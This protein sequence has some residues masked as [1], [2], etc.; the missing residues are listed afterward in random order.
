MTTKLKLLTRDDILAIDDTQ[1]EVVAVPEWG[2]SVTVR[3]LTGTERDQ[4]EASFVTYQ[5]NDKGSFDVMPPRTANVRARLVAI[6]TVGEDGKPLFS[7]ADVAAL[8]RKS[9]LALERVADVARKLAGMTPRD[10]E[11]LEKGL[12][13][14]QNGS[15]GSD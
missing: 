5:R 8:G 11:V 6:A 15:S 2:G 7:E 13:A 10:L 4:F 9:G 1:S 3:G 14:D 12:K